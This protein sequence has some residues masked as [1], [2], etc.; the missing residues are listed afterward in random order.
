M[1]IKSEHI[2]V[3]N[4]DEKITYV[5]KGLFYTVCIHEDDL[6]S[7]FLARGGVS[8]A[9]EL[10]EF[11]ISKLSRD[12]YERIVPGLTSL[13]PVQSGC[14]VLSVKGRDGGYIFGRNFD[15]IRCN[16]VIVK[17]ISRTG[18]SSVFSV[19]PDFIHIRKDEDVFAKKYE[20]FLK[21]ILPC[22]PVDGMNEKGLCI[23]VNVIK[24]QVKIDQKE[25]GKV[26]QVT[27]TLIWTLLSRAADVDEAIEILKESNFHSV[28]GYF[29]HFAIADNKGRCICVEYIDNQISIVD[30]PIVT[31]HYLT[32]CEKYGIGTRQSH[33][34]FQILTDILEENETFTPE[35]VKEVLSKVA[36]TNFSAVEGQRY[37]EWSIVF[38]QKDLTATY[39]RREDYENG[40]MISV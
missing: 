28:A 24:D 25:P 34:R 8:S 23:S 18:Y 4:P 3:L 29:I 39:Y 14:S 20:P 19:N 33:Q 32:R 37:T 13:S 11:V 17:N 6:M 9:E 30:S 35:D 31:N 38:N 1:K 15:L 5:E 2:E 21:L 7:S 22:I 10:T 40:F 12:E 36:K 27:S 16:L 26:N